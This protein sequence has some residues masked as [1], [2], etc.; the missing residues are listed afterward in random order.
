[1]FGHDSIVMLWYTVLP[2]GGQILPD[3]GSFFATKQSRNGAEQPE[4]AVV[5][6]QLCYDHHAGRGVRSRTGKGWVEKANNHPAPAKSRPAFS[7]HLAQ[8]KPQRRF[9]AHGVFRQYLSYHA[10]VARV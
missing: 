3:T 2:M 6:L 1:M 8:E 7:V 10:V 5:P 9:P 4:A